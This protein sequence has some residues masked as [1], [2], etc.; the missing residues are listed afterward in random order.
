MLER[1]CGKDRFSLAPDAK[2]LIFASGHEFDRSPSG[3]LSRSTNDRCHS[4]KQTSHFGQHTFH[5]NRRSRVHRDDRTDPDA[6]RV[7]F[8]S[9]FP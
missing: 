3:R 2:L 6:G 1:S 7:R 9:T 8:R 5:I 4:A